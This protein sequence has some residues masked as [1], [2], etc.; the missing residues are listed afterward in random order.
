MLPS[1]NLFGAL[2]G[3]PTLVNL[4]KDSFTVYIGRGSKWGNKYHIGRDGTRSEVIAKYEKWARKQFSL[5]DYLELTNEV[6]GCH[7]L[8][9]ACHGQVLIKLY[10]EV[11]WKRKTT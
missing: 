11:V 4:S 9:K 10:K 2:A 5:A 3:C 6:L 7:C 8:P 1:S